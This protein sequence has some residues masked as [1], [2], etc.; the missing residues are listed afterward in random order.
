[1]NNS[2][3]IIIN[4]NSDTFPLWFII[5]YC[6]FI[7]LGFILNL[8][9]SVQLVQQKQKGAFSSILQLSV[10]DCLSTFIAVLEV[11]SIN[12]QSWTFSTTLCLI[13]SGG[14]VLINTFIFYNIICLNFHIISSL[15]LHL[16]QA[17]K[18][19][20]LQLTSLDDDDSE[21]FLVD[22]IDDQN[23]NRNVV[24]DYR[25]KKTTIPIAFPL[26]LVWFVGLS[27]SIPQFTL[28][29][30]VI[31]QNNST[32]CTIFDVFYNKLLQDLSMI[33]R[34]VVPV[35]LL[36]LS[37]LLLIKKSYQSKHVK[38]VEDNSIAI[39]KAEKMQSLLV[40]GVSLTIMYI[41]LS[42]Q[43]L[44]FYLLHI[45]TQQTDS[46]N[47][48]DY[49]KIPPLENVTCTNFTNILSAMAHY[50]SSTFRAIVYVLV[51]PEVRCI[52]SLKQ[53]LICS[54]SKC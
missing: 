13:F 20:K 30:T 10:V 19:K 42:L 7:F 27:I 37:L 48:T 36:L 54:N 28:S 11:W 33:F 24:I 38:S 4:I 22:R 52:F 23:C 29:T 1:M 47:T 15:N 35:P 5:C 26:V 12:K 53:K 49:F 9:I 51:L 17:H 45:I 2:T 14:E 50:S 18:T 8:C 39:H 25:R 34:I 21:Q 44:I 41:I 16:N 6:V 43:R 31:V 32:L 46:N 40:L 3:E